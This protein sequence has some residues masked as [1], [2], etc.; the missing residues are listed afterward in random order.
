MPSDKKSLVVVTGGT[1]GHLFPAI[2]L[3]EEMKIRDY[4]IYFFVDKK[5]NLLPQSKF[6]TCK[7]FSSKLN[8]ENLFKFLFSIFI[9]CI[10]IFQSIFLLFK[11]RPAAVIGFGGYVSFPS[12]LAA[13]FLSIPICIYEQNKVIGRTNKILT[14]R[15]DLL[16]SAFK[17]VDSLDK[18]QKHKFRHVGFIVRKDILNLRSREYSYPNSLEP[19]NILIFGGSQGAL[20]FSKFIPK[21]FS[22]LPLSFRKI[23]RIRQQCRKEDIEMVKEFYTREEINAKVL[24]FIHDMD[25]HL[26][27]SHL[28]IS[29][30]G[31]ST[32]GELTTTGTP[33]ILIPFPYATDNH[34]FENAEELKK[35]KACWVVEEKNLDSDELS[36]LLFYIL[37]TPLELKNTSNAAR[38]YFQV[39]TLDLFADFIS[40]IIEKNN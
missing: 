31:A 40:T 17:S 19:I 12:I 11:Y 20:S 26:T 33:S 28:V 6:V 4:K 25:S 37:S 3:S 35:H 5:N 14:K 23:L 39:G 32:V 30:A 9:I 38:K 8:K 22:K 7:I 18:K 16:L 34:Q 27:K 10:G 36:N 13:S 15:A 1:G 21:A 2:A 24:D 29:R